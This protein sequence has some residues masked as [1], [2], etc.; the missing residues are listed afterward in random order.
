VGL[1]FA[2]LEWWLWRRRNIQRD[3]MSP[4]E[5]QAMDDAGVTGD[6]HYAFRYA[7]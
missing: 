4:E 2:T 3:N 1:I 6:E 7:L 5:K